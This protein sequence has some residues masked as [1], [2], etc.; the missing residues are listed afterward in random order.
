MAL[1]AYEAQKGDLGF[2][3]NKAQNSLYSFLAARPTKVGA[4]KKVKA[5][6]G[7]H[8]FKTVR[9]NKVWASKIEARPKMALVF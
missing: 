5:Q 2:A 7:L 1:A 9:P 4:F 6:N 8:S 3:Y